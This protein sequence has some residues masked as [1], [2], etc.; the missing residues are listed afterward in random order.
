VDRDQVLAI[1]REDAQ[2][3]YA[4]LDAYEVSATLEDGD[5]WRIDYAL[6]D[7]ESRGGPH[8][9]ISGATGEILEKRYEQ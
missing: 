6:R 9:L 1:A 2:Q 7:T 8:Y 4:S 3:V 5:V